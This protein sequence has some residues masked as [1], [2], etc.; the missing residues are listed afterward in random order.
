M[1]Q[2]DAILAELKDINKGLDAINS[3]LTTVE[4]LQKTAAERCPHYPTIL[5]AANNLTRFQQLEDAV[6]KL[7]LDFVKLAA[8]VALGGGA[9][10][11][12]TKLIDAV[13]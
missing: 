5:R 1:D 8:M 12:V 6:T 11:L 4:V 10:A 13:S 7:K 2:Y 3:R 9:G